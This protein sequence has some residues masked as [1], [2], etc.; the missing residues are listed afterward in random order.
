MSYSFGRLKR[1]QADGDLEALLS[2]GRRAARTKLAYL[3][4][5]LR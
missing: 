3:E 4:E 2:R 1:A 5:A